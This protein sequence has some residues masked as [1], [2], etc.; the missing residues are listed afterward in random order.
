MLTESEI[1]P[2]SPLPAQVANR[3]SSGNTDVKNCAATVMDRSNTSIPR[4][5]GCRPHQDPARPARQQP[6]HPR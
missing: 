5:R 2:E 3:I 6:L 1:V 4:E